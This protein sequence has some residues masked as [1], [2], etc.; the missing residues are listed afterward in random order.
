MRNAYRI[1]GWKLEGTT[2]LGRTNHRCEG[3][4]SIY[5]VEHSDQWKLHVV[6][7]PWPYK[8]WGMSSLIPYSVFM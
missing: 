7:N 4:V 8:G 3:V 2:P 5:V 6:M 1:M